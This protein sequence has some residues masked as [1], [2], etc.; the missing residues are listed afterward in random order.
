MGVG[1]F[2]SSIWRG[3]SSSSSINPN[4]QPNTSS[5]MPSTNTLNLTSKTIS[6][7]PSARSPKTPQ[8]VTFV[9]S[10]PL[11]QWLESKA[12]V[13]NYGSVHKSIRDLLAWA[14]AGQDEDLE[15]MFLSPHQLPN[16]LHYDTDT[17][18]IESEATTIA[19]KQVHARVSKDDPVVL[20]ARISEQLLDWVQSSVQKFGLSGPSDV[21]EAVCKCAI[22]LKAADDVFETPVSGKDL[23]AS[24]I[25]LY[26][27]LGLMRFKNIGS[28]SRYTS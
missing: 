22:E 15:W 26:H 7:S 24:T 28:Q 27:D 2:L 16:R 23:P 25:D 6:S 18:D 17:E 13:H 9:L 20:D 8:Y 4:T 1:T 10:G 5:S 21:L 19:G 12:V 3:T 14:C 11:Y